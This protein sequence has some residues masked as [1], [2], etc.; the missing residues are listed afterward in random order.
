VGLNKPARG[1]TPEPPEIGDRTQTNDGDIADL[2]AR[3]DALVA[4]ET[5]STQTTR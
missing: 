3:Y 5:A 1:N 2:M 4:M